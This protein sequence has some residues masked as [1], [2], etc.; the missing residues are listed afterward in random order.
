MTPT[1]EA[2]KAAWAVLEW[3]HANGDSDIQAGLAWLP[4]D[5][6]EKIA[7]LIDH[8]TLLPELLAVAEAVRIC[9]L[10]SVYPEIR[11]AMSFLAARRKELE[12]EGR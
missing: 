10:S 8:H 1:K 7:A 6:I 3:L 4:E 12:D 11:F 5:H 2:L 9:N